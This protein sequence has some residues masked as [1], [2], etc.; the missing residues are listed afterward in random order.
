[1]S[2]IFYDPATRR[3]RAIKH[4]T[5][6][7]AWTLVTHDLA[8]SDHRCRRILAELLPSEEVLLVDFNAQERRETA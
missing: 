3:L 2:G 5:V 6:D 7:P 1:M 4:G 8:A